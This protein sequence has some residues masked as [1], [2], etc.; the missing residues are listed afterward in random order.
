MYFEVEWIFDE[1]DQRSESDLLFNY[2][3]FF[4]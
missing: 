2:Y 3:L 1:N 4:Y